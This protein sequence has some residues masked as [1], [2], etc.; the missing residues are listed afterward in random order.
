[1]GKRKRVEVEVAPEVKEF[2]KQVISI[3]I[4]LNLNSHTLGVIC[5]FL[6][7]CESNKECRTKFAPEKTLT[8]R[9]VFTPD[10]VPV[11]ECQICKD[12]QIIVKCYDIGWLKPYQE[13][14]K[15]ELLFGWGESRLLLIYDVLNSEKFTITIF[16]C[17]SKEPTH[18]T[19]DPLL[20]RP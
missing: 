10:G 6:V 16:L 12:K 15:K 20:Q 1:M 7:G 19:R 3:L 2:L 13:K 11:Y 18:S 8:H 9:Y 14:N 4:L 17:T 5:S